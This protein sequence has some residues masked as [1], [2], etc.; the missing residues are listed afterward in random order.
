MVIKKICV[1]IFLVFNQIGVAQEKENIVFGKVTDGIDP[2]KNVS[3]QILNTSIGTS[4]DENGEYRIKANPSEILIFTYLGM[5]DVEIMVEDVTS[6]LNIEME[7]KVEELDEV[8]VTKKNR[9]NQDYLRLQYGI[10]KNILNTSFGFL[11][12]DRSGYSLRVVDGDDLNPASLGIL[13]A[14]QGKFAGVRVSGTLNKALYMR[15]GNSISNPRPAIYDVDGLVTKSAPTY[16]NV[17]NIDRVALIP[18]LAG[19]VRYGSIAAGG[20]VV[21]NTRGSVIVNEPGTNKIYDRAK[22]RNNVYDD[23]AISDEQIE[24]SSPYYLK[25][26][27][28]SKDTVESKATYFRYLKT[29]DKDPYYLI[30]SFLFFDRKG[31]TNFGEQIIKDNLELFTANPSYAKALAY[32]LDVTGRTTL[33]NG[34]YEKILISRPSHPQS[35]RDLANSHIRAGNYIKAANIF[36]RFQHLIKEGLFESDSS[37]IQ[38]IITKEFNNLIVRH[39]SEMAD[40]FRNILPDQS[41]SNVVGTRLLFEWNDS[42]ADFDLQFVNPENHYYVWEHTLATNPNQIR[43]E[44]TLGYSC[45]EFFIDNSLLGKW[46]INIKYKGNKKLTPTYVK[47]TIYSNYNT[48]YQSEIIKLFRLQIKNVNQ[49]F[50]EFNN[51]EN[52]ISD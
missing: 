7:I 11:D 17:A 50:F 37:K 36:I 49:K 40:S 3:V 24:E 19:V 28:Q 44:K 23:G 39:G 22:L 34:L 31:L 4:T 13:S 16:L 32:A 20:V 30:D 26:L 38:T 27:N 29:R 41:S 5:K 18:G 9:R 15:G 47:L 52:F 10:N 14:L 45:E 25:E 12:K 48:P 43:D 6:R 21:I 8:I 42:N 2:L 35:Y 46:Q 51:L 33:S 1:F